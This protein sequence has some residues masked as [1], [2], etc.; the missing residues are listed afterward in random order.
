MKDGEP[1]LTTNNNGADD[2]VGSAFLKMGFAN[3]KKF[4]ALHF[5]SKLGRKKVAAV[6]NDTK[7]NQ[8]N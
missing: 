3:Q 4:S 2:D 5:W 6:E 8:P 7:K 1:A